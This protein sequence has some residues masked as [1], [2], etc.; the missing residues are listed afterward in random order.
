MEINI[1]DINLENQLTLAETLK[2][3]EVMGVPVTYPSEENIFVSVYDPYEGVNLLEMTAV[4]KFWAPTVF[5]VFKVYGVNYTEKC[6]HFVLL[7]PNFES[8]NN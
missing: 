6:M 5:G 7:N 3:L 8:N 1:K 4:S 2:V